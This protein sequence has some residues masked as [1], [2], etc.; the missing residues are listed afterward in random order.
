MLGIFHGTVR[1]IC[2]CKSKVKIPLSCR[3][4][5]KVNTQVCCHFCVMDPEVPEKDDVATNFNDSEGESDH[6]GDVGDQ[7]GQVLPVICFSF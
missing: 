4:N 7:F 3:L 5:A 2:C 1:S 6:G